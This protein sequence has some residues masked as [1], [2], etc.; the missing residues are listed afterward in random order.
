M[1]RGRRRIPLSNL[2]RLRLIPS[3]EQV[4]CREPTVT[5]IS[6]AI[7]SRL[8]PRSTRIPDLLNLFLRKLHWSAARWHLRVKFC[9]WCRNQV[10]VVHF[11]VAL[12]VVSAGIGTVAEPRGNHRLATEAVPA[13]DFIAAERKSTEVPSV[14]CSTRLDGRAELS[15]QVVDLRVRYGPACVAELATLSAKRP[16]STTVSRCSWSICPL[17]ETCCL[18]PNICWSLPLMAGA[19]ISNGDAQNT[20]RSWSQDQRLG[21][22]EG[23][24]WP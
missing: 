11:R 12:Q 24:P 23:R 2:G 4:T 16:V 7:S 3:L 20:S 6:S 15:V 10:M 14:I 18:A 22:A 19:D 13:T 1:P 17:R 9:Q 5:S 8:F 21:D